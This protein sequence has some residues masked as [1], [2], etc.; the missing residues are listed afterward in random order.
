[1]NLAEILRDDGWRVLLD[2]GFDITLRAHAESE[3]RFLPSWLEVIRAAGPTLPHGYSRELIAEAYETVVR[4]TSVADARIYDGICDQLAANLVETFERN[5]VR[6]LDVENGTLPDNPLFTEALYIA[7]RDFGVR[8]G[9]G[10]YVLWR[11]FDLMWSA[12]PHRYGPYPYPG[13][14]RPSLSPHIH[15]AVVTDWM[16]RRMEA[17]APGPQY[18]VIPD[19]F[20]A[21]DAP[22]RRR[23]LREAYQIPMDAYLVARC[24]RIIPQKSIDRDLYVLDA[25]QR[26]LTE[27]GSAKRIFL[28]VAGIVS[29]EPEEYER[30]R[31]LQRGLAIAG[32]VV[33][34]DGLLPFNVNPAAQGEA[35][36]V[37]DLLAE[38]D[39]SSFLTTYDYEGFGNP[40]GEAMAM[41]VPFMAT[42]YELY[43]EVYGS[44]GAI[45]PLLPI[46]RA[47]SAADPIPEFFLTWVMRV[48][49]SEEYRDEITRRNLEVCRRFFSL[50]ALR[51]QL[52]ELFHLS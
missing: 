29:E 13:V 23:L 20:F 33:W 32:Q 50:D 17:W 16:R 14:R 15:Y 18:H 38:A 25:L 1:M 5:S 11:D 4:G 44:K 51:R 49:T 45:G 28:L 26:Q 35:F 6:L 12:E 7:I 41:G 48:L 8:H 19:R 21:A 10:K 42:T 46:D 36:S 34:A 24:T 43:E 47:S 39:L 22:Q 2:P 40:P 9:L 27:S 3:L 52:S 30:L 31:A 37:R